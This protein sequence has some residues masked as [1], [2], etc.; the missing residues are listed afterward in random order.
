MLLP[1]IDFLPRIKKQNNK[2][3]IF[4]DI[5]K[6]FVL[7]TPEEW[8]RQKFIHLLIQNYDYHAN[9]FQVERQ[10]QYHQKTKRT[11][12]LIWTNDAKPYFLIECKAENITLSEQVLFQATTYNSI[13]KANY[14]GITNGKECVC[15][16]FVEEK[17]IYELI[18]VIPFFEY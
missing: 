2:L 16:R 7:L 12:I 9:L 6:K 3:Y 14:L 10:L 1:E 11:D 18:D 4:D 15:Y 5:R 13:Q 17:E 8:V